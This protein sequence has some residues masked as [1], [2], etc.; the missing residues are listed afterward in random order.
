MKR[1]ELVFNK[2][3][4]SINESNDSILGFSAI[5]IAEK[6]NIQRSNACSDLNALVREGRVKKIE[7]KP[8]LYKTNNYEKTD[9]QVDVDI[10][11]TII[12]A[13]LS[14]KNSVQQARAAIIYPPKGLHTLIIGETGTGKSMFAEFMFKYAK[15]AG[16]LKS[17]SP[18]V[19]FNCADYYN[20]PQLLM[21]QLFGV[22]KGAYTG[23][24]SDR[25][26]LVENANEGIL[27]LDEVHRLP[28]EGQEMLFYLMDKGIYRRLGEPEGHHK[29]NILIIA[30][31]TED[32]ESSLLKT[33]TR[34][35]PMIIKLPSL[36]QRTIYERF[37]IVRESFKEEAASIKSDILITANALKGILL[38][39]CINNVGQLKSDIKL[40]CAKAFLTK[41]MERKRDVC[42]HSEDLPN[43]VLMGLL[44]AKKF[45]DE[46]AKIV[47]KDIV[48]FPLDDNNVLEEKNIKV[49]NFYETLE[50]KRNL[51]ESKGLNENDI[52]LIMSLDINTYLKRY[53]FDI[54]KQNLEELYK[55]VDKKIVDIVQNFLENA[56]RMLD[57]EFSKKIF[58]ALAMHVGSSIERINNNKE[59]KNHKLEEIRKNY[60]LEYKISN[61][62][63]EIME[64]EFNIIVPEDEIAFIT[65][66]LI[67]DKEEK[68]TEG[69]VGIVVAM[70]GESSATSIADVTNRLLG[71]K[72]AVGYNMPL[73]QKPAT[74]LVN[75]T[76]IIKNTNG[77]KGVILLVDMGSLVLFG[78]IIYEKTRIP[79]KTIDMVSTPMVLEA[80]RKTL[81]DS[82]LEDVYNSCINLSP[83]VGR[84]YKDSFEFDT[85]IKNDVIITA[86]LT[87]QGAALKLKNILNNKLN[88]QTKGI[89]VIP[90]DIDDKIEFNNNIQNIKR[91]KNLIGVIGAL[92]PE[93]DSILYLST[94]EVFLPQ[95]LDYLGKTIDTLKIIENMNAVIKE[96]L[97]IDS[98]RF[99][100][101]FKLF[102]LRLINNQIILDGENSV[103]LILHMSCLV[104]R[105]LKGEMLISKKSNESFYEKYMLEISFI[106][107]C[108]KPIE[109]AFNIDVP[110]DDI[111]YITKSIYLI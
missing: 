84:I 59:I 16:K 86:C 110:K 30:A 29:A 72:M 18:F 24:D 91:E 74:A 81:L 33:F 2:L 56:S 75:L 19:I 57:R 4:K 8:V 63:K 67:I 106:K 109:D 31:T 87:G 82:T 101:S 92:K 38:Y 62:L 42:V 77:G 94:Y 55:V 44:N 11:D 76:E 54:S 107:G 13:G 60:S 68:K 83:F 1:I 43:Y 61:D 79:V 20:N 95:K 96:Y 50:K 48:I 51:L 52:K 105:L 99:I 37:Q 71:E 98:I 45:K 12:G 41:M 40:C 6:L 80:T 108:L 65:M 34:R 7:G 28:P 26:G 35:I 17:N 78:D 10:F 89:D 14:L 111:V 58:Y 85:D 49:S 27:F 90:L 39:D 5:E 22:K 97:S 69:K 104:E 64:Q 3:C 23:A 32:I 93:D 53:I 47:T 46:L 25:L 100:E 36:K 103:G 70:H 66:F 15:E 73:D 102:Y 88:L 21:S 9:F